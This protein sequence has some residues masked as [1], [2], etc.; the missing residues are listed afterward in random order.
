MF[1]RTDCYQQFYINNKRTS[2]DI[3]IIKKHKVES[4]IDRIRAEI[5]EGKPTSVSEL[6]MVI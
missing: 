4:D 3:H 5:N 6:L 1:M 2:Y